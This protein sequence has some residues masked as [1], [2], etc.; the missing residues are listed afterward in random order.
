[1]LGGFDY[2][3]LEVFYN[4]PPAQLNRL[5]DI[6]GRRHGWKALSYARDTYLK[7][8]N[9]RVT[10]SGQTV[11]RLLDIL[12]LVIDF[13][14]KCDLIRSLRARHRKK[15]SH[16]LTVTIADWRGA[17]VPL[18]THVIKKA[19]TATL[20][21][22]VEKRLTWLSSGDAQAAR[23]ILAQAEAYQGALT[24]RL[25][26][27]E[28]AA[29][30]RVLETLKRSKVSHRI[31]LPY[32]DINLTLKRTNPMPEDE[33]QSIAPRK[34]NSLFKPRAEDIFDDI[35]ASLDEKQAGQI[36]AKAA[37]EFTKIIAEK[38][39]AE[40]RAVN[41]HTEMQSFIETADTMDTRRR[42]YQMKG[43]FE[44]ASGST[45]IQVG[46]NWSTNLFTGVIVGVGLILLILYVIKNYL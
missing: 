14:A 13:D 39:R 40:H 22:A 2:D 46:R 18:V 33:N 4:L 19:Y 28:F 37:E 38:K 24:V 23:A 31:T 15:E 10:P 9:G 21:E 35:F 30:E 5:F 20:P 45:E 27:H 17:V 1:M 8:K 11:G 44:S 43:R 26:E 3:V 16:N 25:L 6:Y 36:K 7:W 12:P 32:G 41:A 42:D 34:D 29:I